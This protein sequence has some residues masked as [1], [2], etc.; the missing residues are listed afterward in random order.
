VALTT[1][2]GKSSF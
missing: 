2:A 1:S